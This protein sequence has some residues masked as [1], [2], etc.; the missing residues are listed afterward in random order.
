VRLKFGALPALK[1][2]CKR[3]IPKGS[4]N[5]HGILFDMCLAALYRAQAVSV[6]VLLEHRKVFGDETFC[7]AKSSLGIVRH[8]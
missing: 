2:T 4:C 3:H 7:S 1:I 6:I 8:W 5:L